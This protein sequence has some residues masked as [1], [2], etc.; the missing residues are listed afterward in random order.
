MQN[1]PIFLSHGQKPAADQI[2]H[3]QQREHDQ[4]LPHFFVYQPD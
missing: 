4:D 3:E 2:L 1:Q